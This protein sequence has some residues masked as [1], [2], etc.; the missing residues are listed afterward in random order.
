M[1]RLDVGSHNIVTFTNEMSDVQIEVAMRK[2]LRE[3]F[4]VGHEP[5]R[6]PE[7]VAILHQRLNLTATP[8]RNYCGNELGQFVVRK[9]RFRHVLFFSLQLR[10]DFQAQ[11][12][13]PD[14][15]GGVVLVAGL[16]RV[17][18]HRGDVRV[19]VF[20]SRSCHRLVN[21]IQFNLSAAAKAWM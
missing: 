16:G 9:R 4:F 17:G 18:F 10:R 15:T 7:F 12:V 19:Q 6:Y 11:G 3:V 20:S 8:L 13:E 21:G 5:A 14:Q 1:L 2:I